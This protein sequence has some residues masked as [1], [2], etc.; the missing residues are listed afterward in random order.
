MARMQAILVVLAL[1]GVEA[2]SPS[3]R[4]AGRLARARPVARSATSRVASQGVSMT[5][6]FQKAIPREEA[7]KKFDEAVIDFGVGD[8]SARRRPGC[9]GGHS[10][11]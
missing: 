9:G 4:G 11:R 8:V 2:F 5:A 3:W 1:A 6:C 10:R 7:V